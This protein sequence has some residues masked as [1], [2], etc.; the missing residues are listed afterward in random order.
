M[1]NILA[2]A[3]ARRGQA[4]LLIGLTAAFLVVTPQ[5]SAQSAAKTS[6]TREDAEQIKS[7]A[8]AGKPVD[9]GTI[10]QPMMRMIAAM[11]NA[12]VADNQAYEA[13]L[14]AAGVEKLVSL[15]DLTPSSDV[16]DHCDRISALAQRA[17]A[18]GK[19]FDDYVALA[20]KQG[21]IEVAAHNIQPIE[22]SGFLD[23][24]TDGRASFEQRWAASATFAH[25]AAG[26]C[27]VLARRHWSLSPSNVLEIEEPDLTEAQRRIESLQ[28]A[29][30][31]VLALEEARNEEATKQTEK[32]PSGQ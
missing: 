12:A 26:L 32:L 29:A 25:E 21:E 4:R 13:A 16:L 20:R 9:T 1:R 2:G 15:E 3:Q 24:T 8:D 5:A 6:V 31:R 7:A 14:E 28:Q 22:L 17:G 11:T 10:Q 19:R 30:Q 18:M 23:G 27:T